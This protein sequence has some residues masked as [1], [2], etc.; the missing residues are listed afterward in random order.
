MNSRIFATFKLRIFGLFRIFVN[1][2]NVL[3]IWKNELV[4]L[5]RVIFTQIPV[6]TL[7]SFFYDYFLHN[8]IRLGQVM[9]ND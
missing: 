9:C 8:L 6:I 2:L 4:T 7:Y 3:S 5:F 1:I